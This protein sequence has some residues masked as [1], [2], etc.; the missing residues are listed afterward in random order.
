MPWAACY[1]SAVMTAKPPRPPIYWLSSEFAAR[2]FTIILGWLF[3]F[4]LSELDALAPHKTLVF[5]SF[6]ILWTAAG[7]YGL[8]HEY[9]RFRAS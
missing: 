6:V 1:T 4:A 3:S 8:W 2:V 7:L 5:Y 9:R